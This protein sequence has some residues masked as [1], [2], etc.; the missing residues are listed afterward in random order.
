MLIGIAGGAVGLSETGAIA[1]TI[2]LPR[3]GAQPAAET[4]AVP[5]TVETDQSGYEAVMAMR[6]HVGALTRLAQRD[7]TKRFLIASA[8]LPVIERARTIYVSKEA[9]QGDPTRE[10]QFRSV[11][12]ASAWAGLPETEQAKFEPRAVDGDS[13]YNGRYGSPLASFRMLD[14]I[15]MQAVQAPEAKFLTKARILDFGFGTIGPVRMLASLGADMVAVDPD[16]YPFALYSEDGD[17]GGIAGIPL[18]NDEQPPGT[19]RLV[20]GRWPAEESVVSQIGGGYDIIVSKNTLKNG[21]INPQPPAGKTVNPRA[22]I[23]LGVSNDA[24]VAAVAGALKPG[25]FFMIYNISPKPVEG[26]D[27]PY[28]PHADGRSPFTREQFEKAGFEVIA[29]DQDDIAMMREIA[30]IL[31]WDSGPGAMDVDNG[32]TAQ[33]TLVRKK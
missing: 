6:R 23:H 19:L 2:Y 9:P 22:V 32:L 13:F 31:G 17:T 20:Q 16:P 12:S 26:P 29:F 4:A 30:K 14:L 21:Y 10:G 8:F 5:N 11:I 27:A 3:L 33:Y 15:G 28:L 25:G 24:F 7:D 1:Q 18:Y